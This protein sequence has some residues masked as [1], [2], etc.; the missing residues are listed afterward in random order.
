MSGSVPV[1]PTAAYVDATGI[2]A[3]AYGEI[4]NFLT[5]QFQAIYGADIVVDPDSQD[6]QLI[7]IFALAIADANNAAIAVYN[8][9][10][11]STAQGIGLSSMVKINGMAR[12]LPTN[13]VATLLL[14]GTAGTV[15][16]NG[17]VQDTPGNNWALPPSVTIPPEGQIFVTATCQ[18]LGDVTAAPGDITRIYTVTRGW[19]SAI[20]QEAATPGAPVESDA[21]LRVR[22]S[23]STAIPAL[24]VL[25][26]I[27]GAVMTVPGVRACV[28]YENDTDVADPVTTLPEHSI[29]MVVQ[30]GDAV[31][32]CR[33]I[34][35]K[36]TPGCYTYG[37]TRETVLDI[38]GL[39]HDIGYFIP[40]VVQI[41]V[42]ITLVAKPGY[43]SLVAASIQE[44][45]AKYINSL[46]SGE[47]VIYSKLWLPANLCDATGMPMPGAG[48]TYDIT[49]MFIGTPVDPTA[50]GYTTTNVPIGI[51]QLAQCY[52][53]D[54]VITVA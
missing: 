15:I 20:N 3:P 9:F 31:E 6:G 10:S 27:V 42:A 17:L 23:Q 35:R 12:Q 4:L 48:A 13:S 11:P 2:H 26:G 38:Y 5:G 52:P 44:T 8:S 39:P 49:A 21:E 46:G 1:S 34:L 22:Q 41:G 37:T 50:V 36:K 14:F 33:T 43:S 51:S 30:G 53:A 24:T 40:T 32:I 16:T 18:T 28:P 47:D 45:V 54:V 19:Q 7:G 25:E 29:A